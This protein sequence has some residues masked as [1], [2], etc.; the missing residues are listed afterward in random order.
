[1]QEEATM[2]GNTS[3]DKNSSKSLEMKEENEKVFAA[4]YFLFMSVCNFFS[5]RPFFV[6]HPLVP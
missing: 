1:M 2:N 6:S 3:K 4:I 5:V